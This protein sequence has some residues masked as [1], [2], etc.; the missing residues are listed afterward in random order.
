MTKK[1]NL[2]GEPTYTMTEKEIDLLIRKSQN[3]HEKALKF[4]RAIGITV[5]SAVILSGLGA[6]IKF[7]AIDKQ[8][9]NNTQDISCIESKLEKLP[10]IDTKVDMI[11]EDV[12][13]LKKR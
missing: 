8:V 13:E 11:Y 7:G 2:K 9:S 3:G 10:S 12:Q 1:S 6:L 4:W 5:A